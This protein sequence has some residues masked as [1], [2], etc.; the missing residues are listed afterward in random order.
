MSTL[1]ERLRQR[2]EGYRVSGPSA[3]HTAA[4]LDEAAAALEAVSPAPGEPPQ[5][6]KLDR[7]R[8]GEGLTISVQQP[9]IRALSGDGK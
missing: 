8:A 5:G 4:L 2:A 7:L 6:W 1:I 3:E 9:A